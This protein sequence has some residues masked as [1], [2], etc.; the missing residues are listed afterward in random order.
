MSDAGLKA[1]NGK[2]FKYSPSGSARNN[3]AENLLDRDFDA[4]KPNEKWVSDITYIPVR[5]GHV[6]LTVIMDLF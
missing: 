5:G 1:R 3:I 6:Y 2:S 4:T